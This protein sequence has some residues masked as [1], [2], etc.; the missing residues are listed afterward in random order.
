M[1]LQSDCDAQP[2][3]PY[4]TQESLIQSDTAFHSAV[5]VVPNETETVQERTFVSTTACTV[6]TTTAEPNATSAPAAPSGGLIV[7]A[8]LAKFI[9]EQ[10]SQ[11]CEYMVTIIVESSSVSVNGNSSLRN[12][13][14]PPHTRLI[15]YY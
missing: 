11:V 12:R 1:G 2:T 9:Q 14:R 10:A 15:P 5:S 4:S 7:N 3:L 8:E 13:N 6:A